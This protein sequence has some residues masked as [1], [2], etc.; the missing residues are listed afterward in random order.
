MFL[1]WAERN[2]L[3]FRFRTWDLSRDKFGLFNFALLTIFSYLY[4]NIDSQR[5]SLLAHILCFQIKQTGWAFSDVPQL[6]KGKCFFFWGP[7]ET[8]VVLLGLKKKKRK[9]SRRCLEWRHRRLEQGHSNR[10]CLMADQR[11]CDPGTTYATAEERHNKE[12]TAEKEWERGTGTEKTLQ[13]SVIFKER[14][15]GNFPH[16]CSYMSE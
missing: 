12:G 4:E 15:L 6:Q 13:F 9:C 3:I 5:Q 11:E 2:L 14:L 7:L 10:R 16:L 8:C 1:V